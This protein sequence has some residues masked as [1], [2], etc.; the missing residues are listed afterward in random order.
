MKNS[1]KV[2]IIIATKNSEQYIKKA[3]E[4]V[5]NQTYKNI[6]L[7]IMDGGSTDNTKEVVKPY[8]ADERVRYVYK[9]DKH[10]S[11]GMNNGIRVSTGKYIANL[12]SDDFWCNEHKLE[13]QV[14]FLEEHPD[15]VL[16]GGGMISIDE[17]GKELSRRLPPEKDEIIKKFMLS[18]CL[19]PHSTTV[20]RKDIIELVGGYNEHVGYASEDWDL[21]LRVGKFGK[22]YNFQEYFVICLWGKQNKT[23]PIKHKNLKANLG[24]RKKYRNDYPDFWRGFLLGLIYYFYSFFPF[25][26]L[27]R[28]INPKIKNIFFH[29]QIYKKVNKNNKIL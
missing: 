6:E 25:K 24:L 8:L 16:I 15:Y 9:E 28:P 22:F 10:T 5:L 29:R 2:S 13:K 7:I 12:D 1:P 11:E 23:G 20:F 27:L 4:S 17:T 26:Q 21:W 3:I 19:I 14:K 18:D